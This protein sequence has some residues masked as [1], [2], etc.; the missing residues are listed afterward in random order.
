MTSVNDIGRAVR[1]M[2]EHTKMITGQNLVNAINDGKIRG[3]N[4]D[5]D[6]QALIAIVKASID[7]GY[8]QSSRTLE[9]I[10]IQTGESLSAK[11]NL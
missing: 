7:Q 9:R 11:K 1:D 8:A 10:A 2:A 4:K 3:I 5:A 6:L